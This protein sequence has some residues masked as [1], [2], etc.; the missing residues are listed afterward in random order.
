[1]TTRVD[2]KAVV[3]YNSNNKIKSMGGSPGTTNNNDID[4]MTGQD[5]KFFNL[6]STDAP[7][8]LLCVNTVD[9]TVAHLGTDY[10]A[11]HFACKNTVNEVCAVYDL[12]VALIDKGMNIN[13]P[14]LCNNTPL[15]VAFKYG[16][17]EL[18]FRLLAR[19]DIDVNIRDDDGQTFLEMVINHGSTK[20]FNRLMLKHDL[21][22]KYSVEHYHLDPLYLAV[23]KG[24]KPAVK[25]LKA[26][27][28]AL[29]G[30]NFKDTLIN[31][32]KDNRYEHIIPLLID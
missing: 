8:A 31:L 15:V 27:R 20:L 28:L 10:N 17:E 9:Y 16:N 18:C 1:M 3:T 22:T 2:T 26:S 6:C 23:K 14:G 29:Y 19:L 25:S 30:P 13:H 4:Y 21:D 12:I 32:A 24:F 7:N 5:I 11:L